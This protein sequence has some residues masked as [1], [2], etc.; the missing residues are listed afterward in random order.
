MPSRRPRVSLTAP[1]LLFHIVLL[2]MYNNM[3]LLSFSRNI[4]PKRVIL[5][6]ISDLF[7]SGEVYLSLSSCQIQ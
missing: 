5:A 4:L 1:E 2:T 3:G 7:G 6:L